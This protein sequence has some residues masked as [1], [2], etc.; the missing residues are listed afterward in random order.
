MKFHYAGK[1]DGNIENLPKREHHPG[2]VPFKEP[3]SVKT[4]SLIANLGSLVIMIFLAIPYIIFLKSY[5]IENAIWLSVGA[6]CSMLTL[7]PHELLHAVCF[8]EDVYMY[9][10]LS[11]GM[12]FVVGNE[13]MS[14][15]RF[16]F[17]SLLPNIVFGIIPYIIGLVFP[18]LVVLGFM[19]L[20]CTGMGMGDYFNVFNAVT[21]MPKGAKTYLCGFNSYWYKEDEGAAE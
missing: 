16:I 20:I 7:F 5:L 11:K 12:M 21:Q 8:K 10:A 15:G 6:V 18:N 3:K 1:F 19:G 4:M 14:K 2:A 13:D 17:M 9:V